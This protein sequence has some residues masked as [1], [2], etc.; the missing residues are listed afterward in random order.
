MNV[1]ILLKK[2]MIINLGAKNVWIITFDPKTN[3]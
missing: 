1:S 3:D 2:I